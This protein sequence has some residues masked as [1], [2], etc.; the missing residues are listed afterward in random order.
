MD[1]DY[2]RRFDSRRSAAMAR[3]GMVATSQ[4]L[5]A[6]AGVRIMQDGGNAAD[7][8]VATAAVLSVV[9]PHMTGIGGDAFA[10]VQFDGEYA[11]L[12]GS[13][14]APAGADIAEY[15]ARTDAE[16]TDGD[17][18]IP[19]TGGLPV[20]VPGT[21]DAWERLLDR[22]GNLSLA[23]VLEPAIDYARDGFPVT[24]LVAQQFTT[25]ADRIRSFDAARETYLP[26]GD[27]PRP[28]DRFDN[29]TLADT[30]ELIAAEGTGVLY[31]GEVGADVVEAVR[32]HGGSLT[33]ADLESHAGEWVEP[34]STEYHGVEVLEHPPNTQGQIALEALNI[35]SEF[36]LPTDPTDPDRLHH[37]IESIKIA[38]ADGY[39]SI[40]DPREVDVP[41]ERM[42]SQEYA[43]DRA[44]GITHRASRY[45]P[46]ARPGGT[47][48]VYLA[49]V[50]GD[51]NAVS[52]I[53]SNYFPFGSGLVARGFVLQNR[54]T[55]F[56]LDPDHPNALAAGKRPFHTNMPAML[57][58][59]GEFR[60]AWGV[61]GGPMQ[62][63]GHL[64]VVSNLVDSKLN[65]QAAIDAPRFRWLSGRE[66]ALETTRIPSNVV[67]NL[68]GRGHR[69]V[70]E[71]THLAA[72]DTF[73]GGQ[74][75]FRDVNGTLIGGSDPRRD[76]QAI[77][78]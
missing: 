66:V 23:T 21:L 18:A 56:T 41:L 22:Y 6:Q 38:F 5:A 54:G 29:P 71:E 53:N 10:L 65:P 31:G 17:P 73:G 61:M 8:S 2:P 27:P 14:G 58:K 39:A 37:L 59:D 28:G 64:Q 44:S 77:G 76:G 52:L 45:P 4:P 12:N 3:N 74:C 78:Y 55:A 46:R 30:L 67:T 50:D 70:D 7:A 40:G 11:A 34:L 24:E 60:A 75:V 43:A 49:S 16:T 68:R 72:G 57:S 69:I 51:G 9:E 19:V 32:E 62:P 36:D 42:L 47:D 26:N 33:L 48:T 13:G 35:V 25:S 20:T 63:Q 1:F 15:R